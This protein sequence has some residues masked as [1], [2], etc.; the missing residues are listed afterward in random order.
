MKP[1][2]NGLYPRVVKH[3]YMTTLTQGVTD[4]A[5]CYKA[6]FNK[7]VIYPVVQK[8]GLYELGPVDTMEEAIDLLYEAAIICLD[9]GDKWQQ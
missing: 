1:K 2:G 3:K 4:L 5:Y 7:C 8:P 6:V 9:E